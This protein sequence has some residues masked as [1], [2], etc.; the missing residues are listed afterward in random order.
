VVQT[1]RYQYLLVLGVLVVLLNLGRSPNGWSPFPSSAVRWAAVLLPAY[2]LL[3]GVPLPVAVLCVV[4]AARAEAMDALGS[5]TGSVSVVSNATNSPATISLSGSGVPT[6]STGSQF[7]V[8]TTGNDANSGTNSSAPWRTIQKAMNSATAGS[9][10]NIMAGT[11]HERLTLG[12]S[13][14]RP[15]TLSPSNPTD[16]AF[17]LAAAAATPV[18]HAEVIRSSSTTGILEQ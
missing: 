7:Y 5:L 9:T 10:V 17:H 6:V 13:L 14:A 4:S 16:S 15:A 3:Q 18:S 11:Y 2:A 12:V 1:V 8:S